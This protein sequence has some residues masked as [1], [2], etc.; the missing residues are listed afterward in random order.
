MALRNIVT[1]VFFVMMALS[2]TCSGAVYRVGYS[3]GWTSRDHVD[4]KWTSTKDFRVGDT[5]IFSY[6]NQFHNVM[7]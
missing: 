2:G 1:L 5:I 3:D 4:Y 7:Q 6:K